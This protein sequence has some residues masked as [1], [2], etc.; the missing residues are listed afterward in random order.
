M[1]LPPDIL[2]QAEVEEWPK[3]PKYNYRISRSGVIWSITTGKFIKVFNNP[4]GYLQTLFCL[5]G[6]R[7]NVKIHVVVLETYSGPRPPGYVCAHLNG[8]K[9]DNR[10]EN[11]RWVTPKENSSHMAIH[12]TLRYGS[13]HGIAKLNEE[14]VSA[15][16][17]LLA[18]G[19]TQEKIAAQF[20][21]SRSLISQIKVGVVWTHVE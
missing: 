15:I 19:L 12:G 11:L 3:H 16:K 10:P 8:N 2:K 4:S 20:S 1:T 9:R 5:N 13:R 6:R 21:V 18:R 17:Q 7:V 14:Q